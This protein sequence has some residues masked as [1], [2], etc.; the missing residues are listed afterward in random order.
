MPLT[1]G[2]ARMFHHPNP[3]I[4]DYK[5]MGPKDWLGNYRR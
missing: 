3:F 4:G 2:V 1:L 5:N